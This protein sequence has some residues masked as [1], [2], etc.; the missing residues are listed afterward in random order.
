MSHHRHYTSVDA[1][2]A[3]PDPEAFIAGNTELQSP[4]LLPELS[5]YL[6]S[7][8]LPIWQATEEALAQQGVPPPYW[9]FAWAGGQALARYL[10]DNPRWVRGKRVLDF[11]AGS[12]L[13]AVAAAKAGAASVEA[14]EVDPFACAAIR[15][16]AAANGVDVTVR[17]DDV[18]GATDR[19]WDVVLAGD[20]FYEKAMS[21]AVA[22]WLSALAAD[23]VT[24]ILGD[25][26][27]FYR[28]RKGLTLLREMTVETT[29]ELEDHELRRTAVWRVSGELLPAA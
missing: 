19:G 8:M 29:L 5:L 7:E 24:V 23:G 12:G 6:A 25:P 15:R 22:S 28:P 20:V 3:G 16:N 21:Q 1:E 14:T 27:R 13:D 17:E 4:R 10:L 2:T 9:A 11:A 26:G 18:V